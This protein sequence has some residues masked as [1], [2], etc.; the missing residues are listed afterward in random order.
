MATAKAVNGVAVLR[1]AFIVVTLSNEVGRKPSV[2]LLQIENDTLSAER[3]KNET[4]KNPS[5]LLTLGP[6]V[7]IRLVMNYSHLARRISGR[8]RR[9]SAGVWDMRIR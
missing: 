9:L 7:G 6:R 4:P 2:R 8:A 5:L 1:L 3:F